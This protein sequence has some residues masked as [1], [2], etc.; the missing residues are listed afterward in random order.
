M[1]TVP[2]HVQAFYSTMTGPLL[3]EDGRTRPCELDE[4]EQDYGQ[5]A[6]DEVMG[7]NGWVDLVT[8]GLWQPLPVVRPVVRSVASIDFTKFPPMR[9]AL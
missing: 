9:E 4:I 6:L 3:R 1:P 7:T 5:A 8:P 2:S